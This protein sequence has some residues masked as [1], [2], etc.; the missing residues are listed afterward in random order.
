MPEYYSISED[1][2]YRENKLISTPSYFKR[3][4]FYSGIMSG[5]ASYITLPGSSEKFRLRCLP[6]FMVLG[7][8]K[9]GTTDFAFRV[10][11]NPLVLKGMSKEL[12]WWNQ[13]RVVLNSS[14]SD[15]SDMLDTGVT[16]MFNMEDQNYGMDTYYRSVIGEMTSITL[17]DYPHWREDRRNSGLDQPKYLIP[18]DVY[19]LN[20]NVK[21]IVLFRNPVTRIYSQYNMFRYNT[22]LVS[23]QY[24][25]FSCST[26]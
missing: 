25:M 26:D 19:N 9:S 11:K 23:S 22:D 18:H 15:Y 10:I 8:A 12:Y 2:V 17:V 1:N 21:L 16:E 4:C 13:Y 14:L 5:N 3:E 24:N 6:Y 7:V 20:P